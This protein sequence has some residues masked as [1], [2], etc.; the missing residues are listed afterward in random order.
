V[1]RR[2]LRGVGTDANH[3]RKASLFGL[4]RAGGRALTRVRWALRR[5]RTPPENDVAERMRRVEA[6]LEEAR[7]LDESS[8]P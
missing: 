6:D 8:P 4:P 2:R 3:A 5:S 7:R 1:G